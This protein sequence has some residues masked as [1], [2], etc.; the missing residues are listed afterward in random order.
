MRPQNSGSPMESQTRSKE[1]LLAEL[2]RKLQDL[3]L[4]HRDRA[5]L[6]RKIVALRAELAPRKPQRFP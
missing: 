4:K 1:D 2:T 3:P 5:I 6:A